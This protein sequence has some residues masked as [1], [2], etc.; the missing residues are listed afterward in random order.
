MTR[1][2][3]RHQSLSSGNEWL[4]RAPDRRSQVCYLSSY[5]SNWAEYRLLLDQAKDMQELES[6]RKKVKKLEREK[7]K[8]TKTRGMFDSVT[9][10]C[11]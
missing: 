11:Y 6:L 5:I 8:A 3:V 2:I 7:R 10:A 1:K 4:P 9:F